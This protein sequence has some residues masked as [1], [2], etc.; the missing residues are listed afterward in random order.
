M[1][2]VRLARR[3]GTQLVRMAIMLARVCAGWAG[4]TSAHR[5]LAGTGG[6]TTP[7]GKPGQPQPK[8]ETGNKQQLRQLQSENQSATANQSKQTTGQS[9][10]LRTRC[11]AGGAVHT[12][13]YLRADGGQTTTDTG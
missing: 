6:L 5:T 1:V 3:A 11:A 13:C 10:P 8:K 12:E 4:P 2:Q 7:N 9:P